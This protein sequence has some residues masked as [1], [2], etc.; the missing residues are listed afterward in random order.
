MHNLIPPSTRH[1]LNST[2][3]L[4]RAV[5]MNLNLTPNHYKSKA[6]S[7][8]LSCYFSANK[9]RLLCPIYGLLEV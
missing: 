6:L 2:F 7:G 3:L 9:E 4:K 5:S 1:H 8:E